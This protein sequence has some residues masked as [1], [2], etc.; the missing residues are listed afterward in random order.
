MEELQIQPELLKAVKELGYQEPTKIQKAI[1]PYIKQGIDVVGQAKT[2]SGKTAAFGLPILERIEA[3]KGIQ[4]LIL[5][6]TRE[7]AEQ[8]TKELIKFSRYKRCF[9]V[10]IYGGV[11]I[12]PQIDILLKADIVVGTPGRVLDHINRNTIDLTRVRFAI[13]DE[14]DRMLDMGFID[15]VKDILKRLPRNRQTMLFSATIPQE[16]EKLTKNFMTNPKKIVTS[17]KVEK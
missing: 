15:D 11:S 7:L 8:I 4:A 3:G 5:A 6:P 12:N 17:T 10:S 1:I 14:A 9:V 13:L 16:I 2:G